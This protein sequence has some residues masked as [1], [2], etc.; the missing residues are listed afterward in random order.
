MQRK[1]SF[2]PGFGRIATIKVRLTVDLGA[3]SAAGQVRVTDVMLQP[4]AS[5]SGWLPH[6]TE[7]PWSSGVTGP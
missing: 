2:R 3:G 1:G 4:G 7:L 6:V 5:V